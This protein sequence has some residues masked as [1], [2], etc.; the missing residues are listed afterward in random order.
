MKIHDFLRE[1]G[2]DEKIVRYIKPYN[3]EKQIE[4]VKQLSKREIE[5][6]NNMLLKIRNKQYIFPLFYSS[7]CKINIESIANYINRFSSKEPQKNKC[8]YHYNRIP[9]EHAIDSLTRKFNI[10]SIILIIELIDEE[11]CDMT[12]LRYKEDK[13]QIDKINEKTFQVIKKIASSEEKY[14]PISSLLIKLLEKC[15]DKPYFSLLMD[16]KADITTIQNIEK[17]YSFNSLTNEKICI[18]NTS[19]EKVIRKYYDADIIGYIVEK[20]ETIK[21]IGWQRFVSVDFT[22]F[23][24]REL[25]IVI[26]NLT[27][28]NFHHLLNYNGDFHKLLFYLMMN[29]DDLANQAIKYLPSLIENIN[30]EY[31]DLS[32]YQLRDEILN[33]VKLYKRSKPFDFLLK[34][35]QLSTKNILTQLILK[36]YPYELVTNKKFIKRLENFSEDS[37]A[38]RYIYQSICND[39][40]IFLYTGKY[41]EISQKQNILEKRYQL[42]GKHIRIIKELI[43]EYLTLEPD[44]TRRKELLTYLITTKTKER[45]TILYPIVIDFMNNMNK[46][47][48]S[49][50]YL[51]FKKNIGCSLIETEMINSFKQ[52]ISV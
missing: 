52:F 12:S 44:I 45:K 11:L 37:L 20:F 38:I 22:K 17:L 34:P 42:N 23:N 26:E 49:L 7:I 24:T 8:I 47:R 2:F 35:Y 21:Q 50:F 16:I 36:E 32:I 41:K 5:C 39:L 19:I 6:I 51:A 43:G 28:E 10:D 14:A 18:L 3:A 9:V 30:P 13:F 1:N 29:D 27:V 31:K 40:N 4:K 15:I 46:E 48:K 33:F 25:E